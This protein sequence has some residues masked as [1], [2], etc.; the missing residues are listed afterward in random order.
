MVVELI[1][2]FDV[3]W[4]RTVDRCELGTCSP[5]IPCFVLSCPST[6]CS[7]DYD[8]GVTIDGRKLFVS[9]P[10]SSYFTLP[11]AHSACSAAPWHK[12]LA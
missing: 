12:A 7:H 5:L 10:H 4:D 8:P 11:S 2:T 3:G 1:S 6:H 9:S